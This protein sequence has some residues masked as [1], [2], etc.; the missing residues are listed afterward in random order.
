[1]RRLV[2]TALVAASRTGRARAW[3]TR[4]PDARRRT[5]AQQATPHSRPPQPAAAPARTPSTRSLFAPTWNMFLIGGRFSSVDGDPARLQRY[6]DMRDGFLF[7]DAATPR[8]TDGDWTLHAR[9]TMSAGAISAISADYERIG[10]LSISGLWDQIP[11]FYSVDTQT[12]FTRRRRRWCSTTRRSARSERQ[13]NLNAYVPIAPQ[14]D[15]RERRDIGTVA[16]SATPDDDVDLTGDFTTT[17]HSGELPWGA[18]F[19]FSN[20]I[21]V[22]LPYDSRTNDFDRRRPV[23]ERA[24]HDSRRLQRLVVQQSRRHAD[25]GQPA[26]ADRHDDARPGRGRTALWPSN[27]PQTM[28]TAGYAK[29]ARRTQ[30]TGSWPSAVWNNDEPL[31]PFTINCAL[32]QFALPRDDRRRPTRTSSSTNVSLVSRPRT[33]GGSAHG[34]AATT[35]TTR[36]RAR[37]SRSSSTTTRRSPRR[38]PA[39]RTLRA[40][41]QYLRRRRHVDRPA[42]GGAH[43][44]LH[45]TTTT[46][47][48][49]ASSSRSD[50][51]VLQLKADAVGSQWVTF[52]AQYEYGDRTGSGLDEAVA[53]RDRRAA[54]DAAL[55]SRGPHAQSLHRPGRHRADRGADVQRSAAA[56]ARTT[57]TTAIS[58][59]RSPTFRTFSLGVDYQLAAAASASARTYNYERYA[60]LQRS[61]SA[62]LVGQRSSNDPLRDWTADST[63]TR[64]LL[65]DLRSRRRAFGRNTEVRFSYDY[66]HAEGNFLYAI[67]AG[68]PIP[69]PNQLP[70][71]FN[72]LQQLHLDVRHRLSSRLAATFSYLYEPFRIYDFAFDPSVVNGIVQPSSLVMGYVYRPVHGALVHRGP[73][74]HLVS[75]PGTL[76][77]H[78]LAVAGALITATSAVVFLALLIGALIGLFDNP[79]AGLVVFVA[80]PAVL[81]L[82]L[83]CI[84]IGMW[85]QRRKLSRH[86]ETVDDWP[87]WDFRQQRVRRTASCSRPSA[88]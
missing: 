27:S 2:L 78:P 36:R 84:P 48:T 85:L 49:S 52:R 60:G 73:A 58:A 64:P 30:V 21:E 1:M 56:S 39:A 57:S 29:L 42:A 70:D 54:R 40:Q 10:R 37:R 38:R 15:L 32:P 81:I 31:L 14:F 8:E 19:G 43:R 5:P 50:E 34:S 77:R 53:D 80:V 11:Q 22:A 9:R 16:F 33:T 72:K 28:S 79:Y 4:R 47:T 12:P 7:T 41:P 3:R 6:Q 55:R 45:A 82:G 71:V 86:P 68:S 76:V 65:L 69:A 24:R 67:P 74:G 63:E 17:R 62:R 66:S 88:R 51:N 44:R 87:V 35:T 13:A 18:S 20:D 75:R 23:D 83:L 59:C 61:R 25:L 26:A 46:A